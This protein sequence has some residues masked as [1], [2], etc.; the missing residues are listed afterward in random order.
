[1]EGE[2]SAPAVL[3]MAGTYAAARTSVTHPSSRETC[4][5]RRQESVPKV[6]DGLGVKAERRQPH[7]LSAVSAGGLGL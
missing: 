2:G 6:N 7:E 1:M 5:G 3:L 4:S